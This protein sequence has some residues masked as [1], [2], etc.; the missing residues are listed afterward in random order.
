MKRITY[1]AKVT[2]DSGVI[3][4][5]VPA[6]LLRMMGARPGDH[7]TF[8]LDGSA[9]VMRIARAKVKTKGKRKRR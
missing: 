1:Q 9:A 7:A 3:R 2:N 6:P 8:R 4:S 5:R